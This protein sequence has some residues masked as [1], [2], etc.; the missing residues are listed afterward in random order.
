MIVKYGTFTHKLDE[1]ALSINRST[2]LNK[3]NAIAFVTET[4]DLSGFLTADTQLLLNTEITNLET[5]YESGGKDLILFFDDGSTKSAHEMISSESIGGLR[6]LAGPGFPEGRGAEYTTFRRFTIQVAAD[7]LPSGSFR[8][9]FLDFQEQL[10]FT[11]GGPRFVM[12]QAIN[13]LP[14]RQLVAQATPFRLIQ[15]GSQIGQLRRF[16]PNPP[17]FPQ[18]EHIDQRQI[19]QSGPRRNGTGANLVFT[20]F[21]TTW[22]YNFESIGPFKAFPTP[23]LIA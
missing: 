2:T 12:L 4:W 17:L 8:S 16:P 21:T 10:S 23:W 14:Q 20:E 5:A 1:V 19:N 3:A 13:G 9:N 11:G 18:D 22:Q 15:S 7:F 6:I